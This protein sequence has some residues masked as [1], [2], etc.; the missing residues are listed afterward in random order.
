MHSF[1][2]SL[3]H[4]SVS[5]VPSTCVV[6]DGVC[7]FNDKLDKLHIGKSA[8]TEWLNKKY[9]FLADFFN[10]FFFYIPFGSRLQKFFCLRITFRTAT[11]NSTVFRI[12]NLILCLYQVLDT[13]SYRH[14]LFMKSFFVFL[15]TFVNI[16]ILFFLK[17][18][19]YFN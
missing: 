12:F 14:N 15:C 1:C 5:M 13:F 3:G 11:L 7:F 19:V 17:L 4:F 18:S 9:H 8:C 6:S 2:V 10:A 16:F